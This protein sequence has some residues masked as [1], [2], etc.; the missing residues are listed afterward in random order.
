M[1]SDPQV[2]V[3]VGL[4]V[5]DVPLPLKTLFGVCGSKASFIKW[6]RKGLKVDWV[7]GL[8]QVVKPSVLKKFLEKHGRKLPKGLNWRAKE[9]A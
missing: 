4:A 7:E 5:A 3:A 1:L 2:A 9:G 6:K 8:G